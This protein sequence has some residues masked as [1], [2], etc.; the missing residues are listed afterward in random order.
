[1][2]IQK[3]QPFL[4]FESLAGISAGPKLLSGA[5]FIS[6]R[7]SF[8]LFRRGAEHST[9]GP[10]FLLF[11]RVVDPPGH[12]LFLK[13]Y[14]A[15]CLKVAY[16]YLGHRNT[17][18]ASMYMCACSSGVLGQACMLV[19]GFCASMCACTGFLCKHVCLH[20][21][22]GTSMSACIRVWARAGVLAP[23]FGCTR[24]CLHQ[25]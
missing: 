19:P 13:S 17:F 7:L 22:L 10:L 3:L 25:G 14:L 9:A 16:Y 21:G 5:S 6:P 24:V 8:G 12:R 4:E 11:P 18:Q 23:E 20:R 15:K 1:M 2:V